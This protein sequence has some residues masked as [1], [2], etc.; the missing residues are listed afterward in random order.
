[1]ILLSY[2]T[3]N[4]KWTALKYENNHPVYITCRLYVLY[5]V[6]LKIQIEGGPDFAILT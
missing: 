2:Y 5:Y 4:N 3:Q 6:R 1:M